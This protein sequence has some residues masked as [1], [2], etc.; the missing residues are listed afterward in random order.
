MLK[1]QDKQGNWE[2]N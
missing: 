2:W 1:C